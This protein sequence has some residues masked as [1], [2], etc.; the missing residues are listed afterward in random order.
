MDLGGRNR[1]GDATDGSMNL[2]RSF[3][4]PIK[5][6]PMKVLGA[7]ALI[8]AGCLSYPTL[9]F[10]KKT[11]SSFVAPV[12]SQ[13]ERASSVYNELYDKTDSM[14]LLLLLSSRDGASAVT[15]SSL[16]RQFAED[17]AVHSESISSSCYRTPKIS[18]YYALS[19]EYPLVASSY[20]TEDLTSTIINVAYSCPYSAF[21]ANKISDFALDN[22]SYADLYDK[23]DVGLT[24]IDL[25]QKDALNGVNS[26]LHH[27]DFT[28]LPLALLTLSIVLGNVPIM[29]IPIVNILTT[30][31]ISFGIMYGV[32]CVVQVV[33]FTPSVMMSLVIAMSVD[34]SLFLLSR[35]QD[36]VASGNKVE[37]AVLLMIHYGGHTIIASGVTLCACFMG[38]LFFP[39]MMLKSVGVGASVSIITALTV[40]LTLTPALLYTK[41]G[42]SLLKP[43]RLLA[44][45][46]C[47]EP[48]TA[49]G[50]GSIL[51]KQERLA[52]DGGYE[53]LDEGDDDD[54]G[55]GDDGL[56]RPL[57]NGRTEQEHSMVDK[58]EARG[59]EVAVDEKKG[60]R[61]RM[62]DD[63]LMYNSIWY[64]MG[65]IL[66]DKKKGLVILLAVVCLMLP[67]SIHFPRLE[68]S[69]GFD[70]LLPSES[71]SEQTFQRVGTHFGPGA[72][73]PYKLLFVGS[74]DGKMS[75]GD[76]DD[77][78]DDNNNNSNDDDDDWNGPIQTE[79]AFSVMQLVMS[80]LAGQPGTP[81]L[82]HFSGI[83]VAKGDHVDFSQ[84][85]I[86]YR[87]GKMCGSTVPEPPPS[88]DKFPYNMLTP[89]QKEEANS[90]YFIST[91]M[92]DASASA[93]YAT[94]ILSVDPFS[95]EGIDW[96][97]ESRKR[98]AQMKS[99]GKMQGFQV[100]LADGSGIE[101]DA[102][103]QVRFLIAC[104]CAFSRFLLSFFLLI[105]LTAAYLFL[106][107]FCYNRSTTFSPSS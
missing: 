14:S 80:S 52:K 9:H 8:L 10:I 11:D 95:N 44:K 26:D 41:L 89:E 16:A 64:K 2:A 12:D 54:G 39:M 62:L 50:I 42:R 33:S 88:C 3:L 103:K 102:V 43:S 49:R 72:L 78:D 32:A 57:L 90:I 5:R 38:M 30:I 101:Y 28:I 70:L 40:N 79:A 68:T 92:N 4:D 77:N 22:P 47:A 63:K 7:Y 98:L 31:T 83:A 23:V 15:E 36:E 104:I 34:Y 55:E 100:Y 20:A 48:G 60:E 37:D 71:P 46:C 58:A 51:A 73:S 69:V 56:G 17:L 107:M 76:N 105:F 85:S 45:M 29:L 53:F 91:Q 96:L 27:M 59:T 65:T 18:S 6:N 13:S 81:D 84:Y 86:A 19:D 87:Y 67:V 99:E 97:I 1:S 82:S 24:G 66:L 21:Y 25:F 74:E 106:T 93:S 94:V 35:V 61:Y 75:N